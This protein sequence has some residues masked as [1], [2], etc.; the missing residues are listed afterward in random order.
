M[1]LFFSS[2]LSAKTIYI[3]ANKNF[4]QQSLTK[5]EIKAIYLDKKRYINGKKLLPLNF[6]YDHPL[7]GLFEKNIL[8]RNRSYLQKYWLKAHYKGHR[9]PK[10]LKSEASVISF[11]KELENAIGY[12]DTN[13]SYGKDIKILYKVKL[14]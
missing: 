7:R 13:I 6:G 12:V 11:V 1:I 10:V 5:K 4:P 14:P 2:M 8:Q 9:P 3:I